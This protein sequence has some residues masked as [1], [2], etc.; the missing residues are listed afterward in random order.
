[1]IKTIINYPINHLYFGVLWSGKTNAEICSIMTNVPNN[2]WND[3]LINGN[4]CK[5][6]ISRDINK[7]HSIW[8]SIIYFMFVYKFAGLCFKLVGISAKYFISKVKTTKN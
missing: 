2:F 8:Y 5:N 1:M 4:T 6:I 3:S 7:L